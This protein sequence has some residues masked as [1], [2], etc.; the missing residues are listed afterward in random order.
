MDRNAVGRNDLGRRLVPGS[1]LPGYG[2][3]DLTDD[4]W[5]AYSRGVPTDE[6]SFY[7]ISETLFVPSDVNVVPEPAS[8]VLLST[9]LLA[10]GLR[11][12]RGRAWRKRG[13]LR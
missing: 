7:G 3:A 12:F 4:R 13:S 8:V 10:M 1:A 9:G 5:I 2:L 6:R 11:D